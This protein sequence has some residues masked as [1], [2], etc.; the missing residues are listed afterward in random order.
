[1]INTEQNKKYKKPNKNKSVIQK[2]IYKVPYIS[3][4]DLSKN[5]FI[6]NLLSKINNFIDNDLSLLPGSKVLL[7]VSGGIDSI[8]L[9]DLFYNFSKKYSFQLF[10]IH[11]NHLLRG[12]DSDDDQKFV[13]NFCKKYQITCYVA[14]G[15]VKEYAINKGKSIEHAAREMRYE[16]FQR[17]AQSLSANYLATAHHANDNSETFLINLFRGSGLTGLTGIPHKR[18]IMKNCYLIR[19][20]IKISKEDIKEYASLRN[21]EWRED[22]TNQFA[23]FTRNKIRLNLIKDIETNYCPNFSEII[24]RTTDILKTAEDFIQEHL[25]YLMKFIQ[26]EKKGSKLKIKL[27]GLVNNSTFIQGELL[28]KIITESYKTP[29]LPL[30]AI[31]RII[32]LFDAPLGTQVDVTNSIIAIRDRF[33]LAFAKEKEIFKV[34]KTITKI[35][36]F[37]VNDI[38][39]NFEEIQ[40]NQVKFNPNPNVEIFDYDL[41]SEVL[42]VRNW[43]NGDFFHPIGMQSIVKVSDFL[44]NRKVA[45]IEKKNVLVLSSDKEIIWVLKHRIN[46]NFKVTENTKRFLKCELIIG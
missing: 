20:L 44:T 8:V 30:N 12:K 6:L 9:L 34:E 45:V 15:N 36:K 14:N 40:R 31:Q 19:P 23:N 5:P 26:K 43:E 42:T 39:L 41:V 16:F 28:Q 46:E 17:K 11:F 24:S 22:A 25:E 7:G 4:T 2:S 10:V 35:G 21:L 18:E 3:D 32:S 27:N 29:P 37:K 1:M 13:E 33:E 38:T